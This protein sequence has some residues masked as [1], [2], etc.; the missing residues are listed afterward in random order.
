MDL[1]REGG[2]GSRRKEQGEKKKGRDRAVGPLMMIYDEH[3]LS[4]EGRK[5]EL[6][7]I[8]NFLGL[9]MVTQNTFCIL[10]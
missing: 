9:I 1:G 3:C 8:L 2:R 7:T 6:G 4:F 10:H 5:V